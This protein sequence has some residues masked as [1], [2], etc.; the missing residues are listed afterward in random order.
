MIRVGISI[1]Q[2]N[3]KRIKVKGKYKLSL[4]PVVL[5]DESKNRDNK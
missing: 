2:E 4:R 1:G 5:K 3:K